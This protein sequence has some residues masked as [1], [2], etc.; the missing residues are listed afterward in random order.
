MGRKWNDT[1]VIENSRR[2]AK[3]SCILVVR[4]EIVGLNSKFDLFKKI[5]FLVVDQFWPIFPRNHRERL[6]SLNA[7]KKRNLKNVLGCHKNL[8][9]RESFF[10]SKE[11]SILQLKYVPMRDIHTSVTL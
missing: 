5:K 3:L 8:Q 9:S 7:T 1:F 6:F 10:N 2:E 11:D 4:E